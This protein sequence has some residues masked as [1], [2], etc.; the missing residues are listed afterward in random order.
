MFRAPGPLG[1]L[2]IETG[3][4]DTINWNWRLGPL[5]PLGIE[6]ES[7]DTIKRTSGLGPLGDRDRAGCYYQVKLGFMAPGPLEPL[8]IET[9][10]GDTIN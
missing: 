6:T 3:W 5:G 7:G 9:G 10:W 8:W 4:G 1:S 2:W